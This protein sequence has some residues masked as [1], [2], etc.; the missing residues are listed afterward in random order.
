MKISL[1]RGPIF[2]TKWGKSNQL[3]KDPDFPSSRSCVASIGSLKLYP[4]Q[5]N[6]IPHLNSPLK[7]Q[8]TGLRPVPSQ[9]HSSI[10]MSRLMGHGLR[11]FSK[12][13]TYLI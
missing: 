1:I 5:C 6:C 3:K 11:S 12:S 7:M 10:A 2:A 13:F 8:R 4:C 9:S